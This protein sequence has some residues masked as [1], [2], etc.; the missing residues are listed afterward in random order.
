MFEMMFEMMDVFAEFEPAMI[1]ERV[2]AG[3]ARAG[4]QGNGSGVARRA[5]QLSSV[6]AKS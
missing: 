4:S 6:S 1:V 5:R 2:K 3:L